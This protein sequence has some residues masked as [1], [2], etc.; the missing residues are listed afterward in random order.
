MLPASKA[1]QF[2]SPHSDPFHTSFMPGWMKDAIQSEH[3]IL[4]KLVA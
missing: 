2:Y 1:Q 4:D 3:K